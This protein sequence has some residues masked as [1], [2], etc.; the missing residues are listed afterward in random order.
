MSR[1][2]DNHC[3]SPCAIAMCDKA[4]SRRPYPCGFLRS[5][6]AHAI[7]CTRAIIKHVACPIS[8]LRHSVASNME[9]TLTR[10]HC[11]I[12]S[13]STKVTHESMVRWIM[14]KMQGPLQITQHS[15]GCWISQVPWHATAHTTFTACRNTEYC[16]YLDLFYCL[17]A[18]YFRR[19]LSDAV[20][21]CL[22]ALQ[23]FR[24]VT[25]LITV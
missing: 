8:A 6:A 15:F 21:C 13:Q 19:L 9:R 22:D 23:L 25:L 1:S 3:I 17:R 16:N 18:L 12:C 10:R 11:Y 4:S 7:C 14:L 24:C 2:H 20:C 5:S